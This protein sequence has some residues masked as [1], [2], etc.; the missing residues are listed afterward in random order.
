[1][2]AFQL[3]RQDLALAY[4]RYVEPQN[5]ASYQDFVAARNDIALDI[6]YVKENGNPKPMV[7]THFKF[8]FIAINFVNYKGCF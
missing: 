1:L 8:C 3:P 4:C 2:Q 5:H 7:R 6:A